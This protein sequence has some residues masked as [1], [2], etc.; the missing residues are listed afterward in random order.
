M[1]EPVKIIPSLIGVEGREEV[2]GLEVGMFKKPSLHL[3]LKINEATAT[4]KLS[5]LIHG[6]E[7]RRSF[8]HA[9]IDDDWWAE[10]L[11]VVSSPHI[12]LTFDSVTVVLTE[13]MGGLIETLKA[14]RFRIYVH[15]QKALI[16]FQQVG[17]KKSGSGNK[18]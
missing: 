2:N 16:K 5:N 4:S 7:W 6:H 3:R 11:M 9:V 1:A 14:D 17:V 15:P 13:R 8:F 12:E 10:Y 18:F